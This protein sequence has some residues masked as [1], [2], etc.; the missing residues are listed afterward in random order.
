MN[1]E[2][3]RMNKQ[4]HFGNYLKSCPGRAI[5]IVG[6]LWSWRSFP[7]TPWIWLLWEEAFRTQ[8]FCMTSTCCR[9]QGEQGHEVHINSHLLLLL[10]DSVSLWSVKRVLRDLT[11][12]KKTNST[13]IR[14][15]PWTV[16]L[17]LK[18][19]S[20]NASWEKKCSGTPFPPFLEST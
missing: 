14:R 19:E 13:W 9:W 7:L 8:I 5:C 12:K 10:L 16:L 15:C 4:L 20:V 11:W 18:S 1:G 3:K 6:N 17:A 2:K